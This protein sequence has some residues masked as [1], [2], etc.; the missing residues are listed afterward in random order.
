MQD[1][2]RLYGSLTTYAEPAAIPQNLNAA[3]TTRVQRDGAR[4]AT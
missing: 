3:V 4:L 2:R 1:A